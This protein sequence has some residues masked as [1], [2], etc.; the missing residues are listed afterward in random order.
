MGLGFLGENIMNFGVIIKTVGERTESL[1]IDSVRLAMEPILIKNI[2]P[3]NKTLLKM[4]DIML[5]EGKDWYLAIDADLILIKNWFEK[6]PN[7]IKK[8]GNTLGLLPRTYDFI[9][10][11]KYSYGRGCSLYNITY[12][13]KC[14]DNLLK[15]YKNAHDSL[16][17]ESFICKL[18][19]GPKTKRVFDNLVMGF[20]GFEQF[21]TSTFNVYARMSVK[22]RNRPMLIRNWFYPIGNNHPDRLVALEGWK[23]GLTNNVESKDFTKHIPYEPEKEKCN[24]TLD[25]FYTKYNNLIGR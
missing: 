13:E 21:H 5:Q 12:I 10:N 24:L 11:Q 18:M 6:I 3:Y 14:R 1:C 22:A 19:G 9:L 15:H 4:Y 7:F 20:H 8:S 2:S 16:I 23:Y 25:E 17:P